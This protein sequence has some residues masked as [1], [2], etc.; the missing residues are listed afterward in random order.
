MKLYQLQWQS[1]FT[2]HA[3]A[4]VGAPD[5]GSKKSGIKEIMIIIIIIVAK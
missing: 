1:H 5:K 3:M 2:I 4:T